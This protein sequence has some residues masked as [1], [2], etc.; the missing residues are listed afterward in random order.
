MK[1]FHFGNSYLIDSYNCRN[2]LVVLLKQRNPGL[3]NIT[4]SITRLNRTGNERHKKSPSAQ[5]KKGYRVRAI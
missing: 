5:G 3:N 2:A 1:S 4:L